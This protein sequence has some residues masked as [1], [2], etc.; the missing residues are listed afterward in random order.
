[1]SEKISVRKYT[2]S[3][4]GIWNEFVQ[5]S[6]NPLFMF[7]RNYMDY[8]SDR[9]LDCSLMFFEEDNLIALLPA[10][11]DNGNI[12]SHGGLTYGGLILDSKAKQHTVNDCFE[13]MLNYMKNKGFSTLLYKTIPH[14]YHE[15]PCEEDIYALYRNGAVL[16]S[17][18]ASTVIDLQNPLKMPKGRKAQVSRAR[19]E[20][21]I[22]QKVSDKSFF[23]DFICL[24]NKV[25]HS[26]HNTCAVHSSDELFMLYERFPDNIHLYTALLQGKLIAGTV[27]YEY[28]QTIH[29]QYMAADETGRQIGGL[30]L[31]ISTIMEDYRAKKKW[32]DF[33][34]STED[35]GR[36]LNE[37]LIAQKEGFGGRTNVYQLWKLKL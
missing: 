1:M 27:V 19:R 15:Q 34:I 10:N 16:E 18:A 5:K 22:V 17:V 32:L 2:E 7:N 31:C 9:F 28:G 37:G 26:R 35:G 3:D 13:S 29:T 36:Y 24:E 4:C 33:G 21:V 14:I 8:H 30:D 12:I 25:L 6:K 20:G 23:D 11:E